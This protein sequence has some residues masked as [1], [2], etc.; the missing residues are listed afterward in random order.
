MKL[1]KDYI[2]DMTKEVAEIVVTDLTK[3]YLISM[4]KEKAF[5][6]PPSYVIAREIIGHD[7][8]SEIYKDIKNKEKK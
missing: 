2:N 3:C 8:A 5:L 1:A 4:E 6:L 7:R